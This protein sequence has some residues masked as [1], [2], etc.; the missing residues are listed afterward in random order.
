MSL[1]NSLLWNVAFFFFPHEVFYVQVF[2][3]ILTNAALDL[4]S[5]VIYFHGF[6]ALV[7]IARPM[8]GKQVLS[9]Q[10]HTEGQVHQIGLNL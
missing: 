5:K 10:L 7:F 4:V 1:V 9:P 8:V 6:H 3:L 2:Y